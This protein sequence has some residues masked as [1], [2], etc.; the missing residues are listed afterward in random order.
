MA[1]P[2]NAQVTSNNFQSTSD[3]TSVSEVTMA[4]AS[5]SGSYDG[6][7]ASDGFSYS[8]GSQT[9]TNSGVVIFTAAADYGLEFVLDETNALNAFGAQQLQVGTFSQNCGSNFI[10]EIQGGMLIVGELS[11]FIRQLGSRDGVFEYIQRQRDGS[12]IR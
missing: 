3:A 6:F 7:A 5:V 8:D 2:F 9:T 12:G 4:S 11:F 10:T 1:L